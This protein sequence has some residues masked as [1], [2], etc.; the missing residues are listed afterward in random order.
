[1]PESS[2][3]AERRE[4]SR[5]VWALLISL[6]LHLGIFG[7]WH[8]GQTLGWWR[9]LT[10]P[11]WLQAPQLLTE[12]LK[13]DQPKPQL[14]QEMP[15]IFVDVSPE[16]ATPEPPKNAT[17][18]SDKNS[19][20]ANQKATVESTVPNI[21][22]LQV[23]VPKTENVPREK[24]TPLQ[25]SA[26]SEQPKP[27]Q[28]PKPAEKEM[29]AKPAQEPGDLALA[30]PDPKP[31]KEEGQEPHTRPKT[32][33]EAKLRPE[34]RNRLAGQKIKQEGGVHRRLN[35]DSLDAKGTEFGYYDKLLIDAIA[36]CWYG[37]LDEQQ[38]ASDFQGRVVVQFRLHY[39]G[40]ISDL[41]IAENTAGTLPSLICETAV[42]KPRPFPKFP[43][44]MRRVVGDV[45]PI[46]FTFY[47]Y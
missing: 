10:L 20:A 7:V 3:R 29:K 35:M 22:G 41:S 21:D 43:P 13:K 36:N 5:V 47:Y 15:L 12:I 9:N 6:A 46:Q 27:A 42:D 14:Q 26:P 16:Q 8:T 44:D 33:E 2:L 37:I 4:A 17:Y 18:Y 32:I 11:A 24:F 30:K 23:H 38:Y 40:S 31:N 19:I 39:D 45:R 28:E 1:M 25:P 34:N